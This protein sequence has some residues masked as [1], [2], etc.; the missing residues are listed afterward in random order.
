MKNNLIHSFYTL[1]EEEQTI[2]SALAV[3][4]L[5]IGQQNFQLLL[6]NI[7]YFQSTLYLIAKP[8]K[9]KLLILKLNS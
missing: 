1:T 9:E 4:L 8:L 3:I 6:K 2:V 7:P 5:P